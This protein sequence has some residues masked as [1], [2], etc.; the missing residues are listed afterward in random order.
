ML[1]QHSLVDLKV[2]RL[3]GETLVEQAS[4]LY[5]A[6]LA[7]LPFTYPPFAA[8]VM[9]PFALMPWPV[10][11]SVWTLGTF[12]SLIVVW[13]ISAG[14]EMASPVLLAVVAG[15]LVLEPVRET[16]GFGQVN[17]MLCALVL[18]DVLGPPTRPAR[19]IWVGLAAGVKL[20]P[21]VFFG[22]LVVT[23]QWKAL[24][25][26]SGSFA[27]TVLVGFVVT[28]RGATEYWTSLVAETTRIGGLAFSSNQSWNAFLIRLT[29]DLD[30]GGLVWLV[31]VAVTVGGGL[32]LTWKLWF[33][34]ERLAAV[35]VTALIGL[36]CSPVSW[37]HH[38]V[39]AIPL[40][41]AVIARLTRKYK[42]AFAILWFGVFTVAPIWWP[43][44]HD[45]RELDWS[46]GEQFTGNAYLIAALVAVMILVRDQLRSNRRRGIGRR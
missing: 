7:G 22:L 12:V 35:S 1:W 39:W 38:W 9:V 15:S 18:Y 20:T 44:N 40:G 13:R 29:G 8:V 30:G 16:L 17:L 42:I 34:G 32:W 33:K 19:G 4:A 26:A 24:A 23:R 27:V 28:P 43:P 5:D 37:S 25:Y 14:W 10:A 3:G 11:V 41:V 6:R 46:F 2:Y 31:L 36:L 45:N 21:L